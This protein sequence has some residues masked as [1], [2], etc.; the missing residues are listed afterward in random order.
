M[1]IFVPENWAE[2][3]IS[4]GVLP[5]ARAACHGSNRVM[6]T[7]V[8]RMATARW[9]SLGRVPT[10]DITHRDAIPGHVGP[11]TGSSPDGARGVSGPRASEGLN[12]SSRD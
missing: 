1:K 3:V 6:E 8:E 11:R 4:C 12:G 10:A 5:E 9:S 7:E 2:P